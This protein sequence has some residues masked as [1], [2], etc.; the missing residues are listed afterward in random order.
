V[1]KHC[2]PHSASGYYA[3]SFAMRF[4][5]RRLVTLGLLLLVFAPAGCGDDDPPFGPGFGGVGAA[6]RGDR[7]CFSRC[8]EGFCTVDCDHDGQCPAGTACVDEHG[9]ICAVACGP[10]GSCGPG[11]ECRSVDRRGADGSV[12]VCRR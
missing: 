2:L 9:G 7:D 5:M 4:A 3:P 12:A 10:P 6:C 11:Y 8:E 1:S